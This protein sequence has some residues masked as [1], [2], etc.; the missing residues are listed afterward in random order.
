MVYDNGQPVGTSIGWHFNAYQEDSIVYSSDGTAVEIDW[1]SDGA[2]SAAG[3]WK[4]GKMEGSWQFFHNN[5]QLAAREIY[6]TGRLISAACY[7]KDGVIRDSSVQQQDAAFPGGEKGRFKFVYRNIYF[8]DQYRITNSDTAIIVVAAMI[9]EDENLQD[10]FVKVPFAKA[11][12]EITLNVF[13]RSPKW[14]PAIRHNRSVTQYIE[15]PV[16]FS[17]EE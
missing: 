4:N 10:P 3:R 6:D 5:G 7:S 15:Q 16:T 17:Q 14:F 13:K 1:C 2:P 8:P 11:F 9:D 12:D